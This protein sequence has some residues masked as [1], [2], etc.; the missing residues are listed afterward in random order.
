MKE[1][2]DPS[3]D[4]GEN[5]RHRYLKILRFF[6]ILFIIAVILYF[7]MMLLL[8][9]LKLDANLINSISSLIHERKGLTILLVTGLVPVILGTF[10]FLSL[11][12]FLYASRGDR[13]PVMK[14]P[15]G[16]SIERTEL[17]IR[18]ISYLV[19]YSLF[20]MPAILGVVILL[21]YKVTY[22]Q[23]L[24]VLLFVT[25]LIA[26]LASVPKLP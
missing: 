3:R 1:P 19:M 11:P 17:T 6:Y 2:I 22:S 10:L 13:E 23:G 7:V 25:S 14:S 24:F 18:F 5:L 15:S 21:F 26:L 12:S 20:E 16:E 4:S 8:G 9:E